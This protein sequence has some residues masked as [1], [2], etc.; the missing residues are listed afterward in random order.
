M[1]VFV[2][3]GPAYINIYNIDKLFRNQ[4]HI[5]EGLLKLIDSSNLIRLEVT[6]NSMEKNTGICR[7]S[8]FSGEGAAFRYMEGRSSRIRIGE[9]KISRS[10]LVTGV[11]ANLNR[12]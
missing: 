5:L 2:H 12:E 7:P 8:L 4:S 9:Y 10:D 1:I 3:M 11:Y 6:L